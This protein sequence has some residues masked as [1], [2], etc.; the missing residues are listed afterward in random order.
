MLQKCGVGQALTYMDMSHSPPY[1]T[2]NK[3]P[4]RPLSFSSKH[5]GETSRSRSFGV[6]PGQ[7][8]RITGHSATSSIMSSRYF[9]ESQ[10]HVLG[11]HHERG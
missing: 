4:K 5:V 10:S 9:I 8:E 6:I 11:F 2:D 7:S 1:Q 3:H